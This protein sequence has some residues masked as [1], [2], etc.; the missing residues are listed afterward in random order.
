MKHNSNFKYDL[1][2]GK[3]GEKYLATILQDRMIE[4]KTDYKANKTGNVFVEYH[5]RD[6]PSGISTSQSEFYAF[7]LSNDLIILITL[8]KLKAICR[9]YLNT[10]RDVEGGDNDTS[11]GILLPITELIN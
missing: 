7:V 11:K 6:K 3:I 1:K 4:V 5:S 2:L 8:S 9:P 10:P